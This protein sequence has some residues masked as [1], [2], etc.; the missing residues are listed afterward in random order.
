VAEGE[1]QVLEGLSKSK[2]GLGNIR[3]GML[4]GAEVRVREIEWDRITTF[5]LEQ[6]FGDLSR[7]K[8][9][10]S[11]NRASRSLASENW[12]SLPVGVQVRSA[13]IRIFMP[14]GTSLYS[15]LHI[16]KVQLSPAVKLEIIK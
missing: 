8:Y 13:A 16:K 9:N 3:K 5:T 6:Y 14:F 2:R 4:R 12:L 11:F 15:L 1:G 10:F 7:L